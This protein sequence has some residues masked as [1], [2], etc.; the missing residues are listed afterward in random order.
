MEN[1]D[2]KLIDELTRK[3]HEVEKRIA[4]KRMALKACTSSKALSWLVGDLRTALLDKDT[5]EA[6]LVRLRLPPPLF[7]LL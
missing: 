2:S 4:S 1:S 7:C 3:L 5:L 6:K